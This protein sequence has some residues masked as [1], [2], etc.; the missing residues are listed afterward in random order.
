MTRTTPI[1]TALLIS[2]APL[3]LPAQEEAAAP[4]VR[5]VTLPS[6]GSPL[7]AV[8]LQFE[9]GSIDDPEGREGL[10]AL[11]GLMLADAGTAER[12]Y[13]DLVDALYPMAASIDV[14]TDRELTVISGLVHVDTLADYTKLLTEAVLSPGFRES[15]FTRNKEQLEAYLTNTL[16]A[17]N[18]EL[19]G[20]ETLQQ[21]LF[22]GHAYEHSPAGTVRGLAAI[23]LDD[24]RAF[25]ASHF[26]RARLTVGV[27]GGYTE[28]YPESLAA[29]LAALPAGEA[30]PQP[31]VPEPAAVEGRSFTLV[32]KKT[33]SVGI[34]FGHSLPLTRADADYYPLMVANSYLGEHRTFHGRLM[35]QLRGER[36]LNYGDYS[37]IEYW[38]AP[39]FTSSPSPGVARTRQYFSVWI[40]PVQPP[41][42]H[43]ALRAA[44]HEV[45]RLVE[46]GLTAEEL[47]LTRSFLVNYSKLWAQTLPDR[48]G[49]LM[50]S[51][52][53][54]MPY[55]IDEIE[56]RL[57]SL[58]LATV[59][60]AVR[61]HLSTDAYRAVLVTDDAEAVKA[62]LEADEP[63][64]IEYNSAKPEEILAA[65][66]TIQTR[67]VAPTS[68]V[69]VPAEEMF[70]GGT[71]EAAAPPTGG[72]ATPSP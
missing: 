68:V 51:E 71:P 64:P 24:V 37:Y 6:P 31:P 25:Y 32:A 18:D 69:I 39:P 12:G 16:R 66:K 57:A 70:E 26:T 35:Q 21:V 60:A 65:D 58:D 3:A 50:D 20:L 49:F 48:L 17:A 53:L 46:R 27:A 22:A 33:D 11:T 59:N 44:L 5:T 63:S 34:H 10:A 56:T 42:A 55:W 28:G 8:R 23:G 41:T 47:D 13:A 1:A 19:L 4:A 67:Q 36:G 61:K 15:D 45:D 40:R 7:V 9:V 62:Y 72:G 38:E 29:A 52:Y 2:L 54:G 43:F 30:R 14:N